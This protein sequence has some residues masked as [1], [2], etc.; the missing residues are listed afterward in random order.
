MELSPYKSLQGRGEKTKRAKMLEVMKAGEFT[1][2][3]LPMSKTAAQKITDIDDVEHV[4]TGKHGAN[5]YSVDTEIIDKIAA[6]FG[7]HIAHLEND[8]VS[9]V[10]QYTMEQIRATLAAFGWFDY[11]VWPELERHFDV[12]PSAVG[13]L[14][15]AID[16]DPEMV[17]GQLWEKP[18]IEKTWSF[19]GNEVTQDDIDMLVNRVIKGD[20]DK[21]RWERM[22]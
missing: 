8:G 21:D 4:G 20:M 19:E 15:V 1:L 14:Y 9:W 3:E 13:E 18:E 17:P 22:L 5:L 7:W 12:V 11:D 16:N 10:D 2:S 6:D